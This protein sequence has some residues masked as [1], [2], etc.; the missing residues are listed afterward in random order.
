MVLQKKYLAMVIATILTGNSYASAK[1]IIPHSDLEKGNRL[2]CALLN[3]KNAH[4]N[5][6]E[7]KELQKQCV[8]T[9]DQ[10]PLSDTAK[11]AI[12]AGLFSAIGVA[13]A[14]G[15][16]HDSH[17]GTHSDTQHDSPA[18]TPPDAQ[19]D[20]PAPTPPDAQHD[21]P[22]PTP[23]DAQHDS[24]AP[25]S[26][27]LFNY[28]N[29][30]VDYS[31]NTVTLKGKLD[32]PGVG[33]VNNPVFVFTRKDNNFIFSLL[34]KNGRPTGKTI[35]VDE[36]KVVGGYLFISGK[37]KNG[38]YWSLSDKGT[39]EHTLKKTIN[40]PEQLKEPVNVDAS[41]QGTVGQIVNVDNGNIK[42]DVVK[43]T[44][45]G[46][47]IDITGDK[48]TVTVE[49][50]TSATGKDSSGIKV[51]GTDTRVTTKGDTTVSGGGTGIDI[52][53]DK[54]TVT[55]EGKTS[56]TGKDSSGIKVAGTD[57][58][59][60]AKG[61]IDASKGATGINVASSDSAIA[62]VGSITA[63]DTSSVGL[64]VTGSGNKI[65]N[66]GTIT[67]TQN[68]VGALVSGDKNDITLDGNVDVNSITPTS[69][70]TKGVAVNGDN[71]KINVNGKVTISG[72]GDKNLGIQSALN[73][74]GDGNHLD[75]NNGLIVGSKKTVIPE[76]ETE[77]NAI[78]GIIESGKSDIVVHGKSLV[79]ATTDAPE[80]LH[81]AQVNNGGKLTLEGD[82][83]L[84]IKRKVANS[85]YIETS[86]GII[87]VDSNS[88]VI[89]RGVINSDSIIPIFYGE[90]TSK[91][92][93]DGSINVINEQKDP[94]VH[95]GSLI[96]TTAGH[97]V[98][99]GTINLADHSLTVHSGASSYRPLEQ[100]SAKY[101]MLTTTP[102][103]SSVGE[104]LNDAT[105]IINIYGQ[106]YGVASV[107]GNAINK[108]EINQ[109]GF[110]PII[111]D[112][113]VETGSNPVKMTAADYWQRG[114]GVIVGSTDPTIKHITSL[115]INTGKINI[116]NSGVGMLALNGG[117]V[118][119]QGEITL[120][121][122]KDTVSDGSG[123]QLIGMA[124]YGNGVAFNDKTGKIIID[125]DEGT[126]FYKAPDSTGFVI[127]KGIIIFNKT[128]IDINDKHMGSKPVDPEVV[129][130]KVLDNTDVKE[131]TL[132]EN[133]LTTEGI[134]NV[135]NHN[136]ASVGNIINKGSLANVNNLQ[137]TT[138]LYNLNKIKAN[139][140]NAP[141]SIYNFDGAT[142]DV[143]QGLIAS[144]LYNYKG[145]TINSADGINISDTLFN[146]K[147]GVINLKNAPNVTNLYNYENGTVSLDGNFDGVSVYNKSNANI[148]TTKNFNIGFLYNDKD[149]T[150]KSTDTFRAA[151]IINK[152]HLTL[153]KKEQINS[154]RLFNSGKL[155]G[156]TSIRVK[157]DA[158]YFYNTGIIASETK[159]D[160]IHIAN[161][162]DWGYNSGTITGTSVSGGNAVVDMNGSTKFWNDGTLNVGGHNAS[163]ILEGGS[164]IAVNNGIINLGNENDKESSELYAFSGSG[165]STAINTE[166]G[167]INIYARDSSVFNWNN[168]FKQV[169]NKGTINIKGEGAG[170]YKGF[171]GHEGIVFQVED[172]DNAGSLKKE[173][174][175]I[176]PVAEIK[177]P[178]GTPVD[179]KKIKDN[180][181]E[182]TA[183]AFPE[184][185]KPE[186]TPSHQLFG[187]VVG[188][189]ADGSA[190]QLHLD[191]ASL[192][193]ARI[194]TGFTGGTA[195][196]HMI[197]KQVFTGKNIHD[198]DKIQST[199]AVWKAHGYKDKDGNVNVEMTK[200]NYADI[201][202]DAQVTN[203]ANALDKAYTNNGL[204]NSL[205][206]KTG[207]QVQEALRQ[208]SGMQATSAFDDAQVLTSRFNR[209]EESASPLN[210][211]LAFNVISRNDKRAEMG[212]NVKYDMF[213]LKQ[214][215]RTGEN[216]N[217]ELGYGLAL[218]NGG[219]SRKAGDNGLTGGYSQFMRMK[220]TLNF[221]NDY[222]WSNTF[223]YNRHEL[224]SNRRISFGDVHEVANAHIRQQYLEYRTEGQKN[225]ALTDNLTLSPVAGFKMRHIIN[226]ALQEQGAGDFN[227]GL[228]GNEQT[229]VDSIVGLHLNYIGENGWGAQARLE[230]GPNLSFH[231]QT[232]TGHLQ[233]AKGVNFNVNDGHKG[234]EMNGVAQIGMKYNNDNK[235]FELNA[236]N[237]REDGISD[238]GLMLNMKIN[239][240]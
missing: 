88:L 190:G 203:V 33:D 65:E 219:G 228:S 7:L 218:L 239:F 11:I 62:N 126:A 101:A 206:L 74:S 43:V 13:G 207:Q 187:Y 98:N 135:N 223:S 183:Q 170:I 155:D 230:G 204:F 229:A 35:T 8:K 164:S 181:P 210:N 47:G 96:V 46:T 193:G 106:N 205:N 97:A 140:I 149:A 191:D 25:G 51:A 192:Q 158:G 168:G 107:G 179:S 222:S 61:D 48:S 240:H 221:G 31:T 83:T 157:N 160:I 150:F 78:V 41:G 85:G 66:K 28:P 93:N 17:A 50:K 64:N 10:K 151:T 37:E 104:V 9:S 95:S 26:Q 118:I 136:I 145:A 194:D 120:T 67:A 99:K 138:N 156:S 27:H 125:A 216:Q 94:A 226:S 137:T 133:G 44:D 233:G 58:R 59:V 174:I 122:D 180:I 52:T 68:G 72:N 232:R 75:I 123:N 22:A 152:G 87:T 102:W 208:L 199:S 175:T 171:S 202:N 6:S 142:L 130:E 73:V 132:Y 76:S 214:T 40:S 234:G 213:A 178:E 129:S 39:I 173:G 209:L 185:K 14:T 84:G 167:V 215:F 227:L 38:T 16:Q 220:H 70:T 34:D 201:V 71:N 198:A 1:N 116:K 165:S 117:T 172:K 103:N 128:P 236:Y 109:N 55:V 186:L 80:R 139:H 89:N 91:I 141:Q 225:I 237:W 30:S 114:G 63:S 148:N 86:S 42:V 153:E 82:S 197:F 212:N 100:S 112:G 49:G 176:K 188:T 3:D 146:Y 111:K 189:N 18:P 110:L 4:L 108:G 57:T 81:F 5:A 154:N 90:D 2:N 200:N 144:T 45:G 166:K 217:I 196:N 113:R 60:T 195:A 163:A 29:G 23:P 77:E 36:L 79:E 177:L 211:G 224:N 24:P 161:I 169:I 21:S 159:D 56:A 124:I 115:G 19:H 143:T 134:I 235:E 105:G 131:N 12:T 69:A 15:I 184:E 231:K 92:I 20:S 53:G 119:N 54:S 182:E 32:L 127:N 121:A 162:K 147:G 238:K